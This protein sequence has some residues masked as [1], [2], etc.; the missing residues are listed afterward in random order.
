MEIRKKQ[1]LTN[2][3]RNRLKKS[4]RKT[5]YALISL[6]FVVR[7]LQAQE[8]KR[9]EE[10]RLQTFAL[11][12]PVP[13]SASFRQS[14]RPLSSQSI[15]GTIYTEFNEVGG[16]LSF[17]IYFRN[18]SSQN[19]ARES[20]ILEFE[21]PFRL[22]PSYENR[23][24]LYSDQ[25]F[26][27]NFYLNDSGLRLYD[28]ED[29]FYT[30][31]GE[32]LTDK[33]LTLKTLKLKILVE[34]M[35]HKGRGGERT[36]YKMN[37]NHF[38]IYYIKDST[39]NRLN[40]QA[41]S[42]DDGPLPQLAFI[43]LVVLSEIT[44]QFIQKLTI[45]ILIWILKSTEHNGVFLMTSVY[46]LFAPITFVIISK[47]LSGVLAVFF[48]C[49]AFFILQ[50]SNILII[51]QLCVAHS[52]KD[53]K[54]SNGSSFWSVLTLTTFL[55]TGWVISLVFAYNL[56]LRTYLFFAL[57]LVIDLAIAVS[58]S[59]TD[60]REQVIP[61]ILIAVRGFFIQMFIYMNYYIFF[62]TVHLSGPPIFSSHILV[63]FGVLG[64]LIAISLMMICETE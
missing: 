48:V 64:A 50:L 14:A 28:L 36:V 29:E 54:D 47:Y 56:I 53:S 55:C 30:F 12:T 38:E 27:T 40:I 19:S 5:S 26:G 10:G 22:S 63:D 18:K 42:L 41:E 20:L 43:M 3:R 11:G 8:N 2:I 25:A 4:R 15:K 17:Q 39:I 58:R 35:I 49:F 60:R 37:F 59:K 31:K 45:A 62:Y 32:D 6:F 16:F 57:L 34:K 46:D 13:T 9:F 1:I 44:L 61:S 33:N 7:N 23:T 24:L 51:Y 52:K 21:A